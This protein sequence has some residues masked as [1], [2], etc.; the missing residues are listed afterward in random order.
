MPFCPPLL[1]GWPSSSGHHA[2][3]PDICSIG[4]MGS[5]G[6]IGSIGFLGVQGRRLR[7]QRLAEG[8]SAFL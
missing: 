3:P 2:S 6:F 8:G 1:A 7:R 4:F 5:I